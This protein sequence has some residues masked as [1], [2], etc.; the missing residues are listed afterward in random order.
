MGVENSDLT[1]TERMFSWPPHQTPTRNTVRGLRSI[2]TRGSRLP[3]TLTS[4]DHLGPDRQSANG[5]SWK[6]VY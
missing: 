5:K 2:F 3:W 1:E 6:Y 4:S